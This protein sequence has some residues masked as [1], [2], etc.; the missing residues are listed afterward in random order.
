V[1]PTLSRPKRYS[2]GILLN[3]SYVRELRG[4]MLS[5][6]RGILITTARVSQKTIDEEALRDESRIVLVIDGNRLI[7]LCKSN[8]IGI[9]ERYEIDEKYLS[10]IEASEPEDTTEETTL[11]GNKLTTENDIRARIL[12]LPREV[13]QLITGK[14]SLLVDFGDGTRHS[15]NLDKQG[16][17]LGGFTEIFREHGLLD[18]EGNPHEMYADWQTSED[19]FLVAFRKADTQERPDIADVLGRIFG[20]GFKR[21]AG[22]SIFVG[23]G[24][25]LLCRYSKGYSREIHY[26]YGIT[27]KDVKLMKEKGVTKLA[28]FCS[29]KAVVFM[30]S[31]YFLEQVKNLNATLDESG[32]IRH[33]HVFLKEEEPDSMAWIQKGGLKVKLRDVHTINTK[34]ES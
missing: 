3:P 7:E 17:F 27:P 32:G 4:S 31:D 13:K 34:T 25:T 22:T 5:G 2:P 23:D 24:F 18:E 33:Y 16:D 9:V 15:L 19:G 12:R 10:N 8:R 14:K 26:W 29:T 6:Q 21:T 30:G 11:V 1:F 20:V 28:F